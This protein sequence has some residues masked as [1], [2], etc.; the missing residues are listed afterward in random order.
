MFEP[1]ASNLPHLKRELWSSGHGISEGLNP[2][3]RTICEAVAQRFRNEAVDRIFT[4]GHLEIAAV[5]DQAAKTSQ[6]MISELCR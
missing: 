3:F 2:R 1:S 6:T 4:P 5:C